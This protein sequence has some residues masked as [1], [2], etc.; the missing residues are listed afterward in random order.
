MNRSALV[1]S[2]CLLATRLAA[3]QPLTI[4]E[5]VA[6]SQTGDPAIRI[7]EAQIEQASAGIRLARTAYLPRIDMLAQLNRGTY[8]NTLGIVLPQQIFMPISGPVLP[9]S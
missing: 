5:A 9:Q 6:R 1:P 7:S 4:Q 2:L 8:N 3:Q